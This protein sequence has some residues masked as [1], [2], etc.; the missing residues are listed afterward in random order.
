ME[1]PQSLENLFYFANRTIDNGYIK[2]WAYKLKCP[3]CGAFMQKPRNKFGRPDKK[4]KYYEC[5]NCGFKM[6]KKE[7]ESKIIIN[8]IYKCPHCGHEGETTIE[9]FKRKKVDGKKG[10]VFSCENCGATLVI[11]KLKG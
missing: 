10:I 3:K 11:E 6:D 4:A 9:G 1:L 5:P 8:V 2:A 7:Y